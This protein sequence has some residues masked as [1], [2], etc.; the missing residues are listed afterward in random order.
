M[1]YY[2]E[3]VRVVA[4]L[5][6]PVVPF[7]L[8]LGYLITQTPIDQFAAWSSSWIVLA[9]A[10]QLAAV[11][12]LG[13]EASAVVIITTVLAINA[14]HLL[15]SAAI[16]TKF[17]QLPV[18]FRAVGSYFLLDQLFAVV[19]P[20]P[21][22]IRQERLIGIW[23]GA[24]STLWLGWQTSVAAGIWIGDVLP[25]EWSLGYVVPL[26]FGGLMALSIRNT[27]GFVAAG[28][29][30]LVAVL[31]ASLPSGVGLVVAI[32][33]GAVAGATLEAFGDEPNA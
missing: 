8:V 20:L 5:V 14:R 19:E 1:A 4:P 15:Y 24:G 9:G 27:A 23:L 12:L 22:N 13:E 7:G 18:W 29:A 28:T 21:A 25:T 33:V 10:A 16:N 26:L 31:G 17:S 6:V 11:E 32:L 2:G 3:G 30:G